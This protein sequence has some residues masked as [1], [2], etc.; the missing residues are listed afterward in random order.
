MEQKKFEELTVI[1]LKSLAY[2]LISQSQQLQQDLVMVQKRIVELTKPVE[3][4][5]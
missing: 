3:D 1:E 5:E 2:D 4:K